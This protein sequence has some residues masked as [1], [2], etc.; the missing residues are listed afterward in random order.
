MFQLKTYRNGM[1]VEKHSFFILNRGL[2]TGKPMNE[3]CPNCFVCTCPTENEKQKMYWLL[4]A[5]WQSKEIEYQ[6]IGSVIPFIRIRDLEKIIK[7][8]AQEHILSVIQKSVPVLREFQQKEQTFL[9]M[10]AHIREL[11]TAFVKSLVR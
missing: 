8:K 9:Q 6:L 1:K 10:S 5:L 7:Q 2:N 11:K 4:F 3:P